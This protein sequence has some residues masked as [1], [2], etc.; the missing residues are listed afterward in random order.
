MQATTGRVR[1]LQSALGQRWRWSS[2]C[3]RQSYLGLSIV[4][5]RTSPCNA[6][7][8]ISLRFFLRKNS[9][10]IVNIFWQQRILFTAPLLQLDD[11]SRPSLNNGPSHPHSRVSAARWAQTS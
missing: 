8:Q 7:R 3:R 4:A 6:L 11:M 1:D 9:Q 10:G 2:V 5:P